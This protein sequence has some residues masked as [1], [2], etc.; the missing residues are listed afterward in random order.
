MD[1]AR[2]L[3]TAA[4][5]IALGLSSASAYANYVFT[6]SGSSGNFVGQA[7]EPWTLNYSGAPPNNWGSPGV[8]AG[9]TPYLE[10]DSA[11]GLDLTFSGVGP[12]DPAQ[13]VIGNAAECSGGGGGGTTMCN[14]PFFTSSSIWQ[15]FLTGTNSISFRAQNLS[16]V[17]DK[18]EQFFVNVFFTDRTPP[19]NFSF[20]GVWIT[21]F[22]PTPGQTPIPGAALLMGSVLA[23]GVGFGAWRRRRNDKTAA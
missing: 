23:G 6:G 2:L 12:L 8:G 17:L 21:E 4:V 22:S 9:T 5:T 3:Q 16:Q 14:S 13:I 15:A 19:T 18:G 20:T 11:F 7:S 1:I 10:N